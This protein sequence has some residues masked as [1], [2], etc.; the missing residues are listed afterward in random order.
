MPPRWG[1]EGCLG[2][3]FYRDAAPPAL[4]QRAMQ[5]GDLSR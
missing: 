1:S 2:R 3:V 5:R 4:K